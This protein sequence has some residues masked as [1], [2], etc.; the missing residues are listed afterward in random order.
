MKGVVRNHLICGGAPTLCGTRLSVCDIT[1]SVSNDGLDTTALDWSI[2]P[3]EI[4]ACLRYC[5]NLDCVKEKSDLPFC[6]C[7]M[8][9]E[10][11]AAQVR[12]A[13]DAFVASGD[14][15]DIGVHMPPSAYASN[16]SL[17]WLIAAELLAKMQAPS[18]AAHPTDGEG[19]PV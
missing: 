6:H 15:A 17:A 10:V 14:P 12:E 16:Q 3:D 5:A 9:S 7:C 18:L 4:T 11:S 13:A 19:G 2:T 1:F 8:L